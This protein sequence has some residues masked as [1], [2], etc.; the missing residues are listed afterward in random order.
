VVVLDGD[1]NLLM[2][3][4]ILAMISDIK[5]KNLVHIVLDN[6]CY[7]ST[8]GQPAISS[9]IDLAQAAKGC[10][11]KNIIKKEQGEDL[12]PDLKDCLRKEGPGFILIKV[13]RDPSEK[14]A[15]VKISPPGI[16]KRFK[17]A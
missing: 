5:P 2:N 3:L 12:V 17:D 8:G 7:D 13:G 10:G 1:G 14:A 11:I 9:R 15:R 6:E 4:G 16:A